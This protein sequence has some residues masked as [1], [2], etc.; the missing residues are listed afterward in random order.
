MA[1]EQHTPRIIAR[2]RTQSPGGTLVTK[3]DGIYVRYPIKINIGGT[4]TT[5]KVYQRLGSVTDSPRDIERAR[6]DHMAGVASSKVKPTKTVLLTDFVEKTY[7]PEV[8]QEWRAST[9]HSYTALWKLHIKP[10]A[11][12]E[13]DRPMLLRDV[14]THD[15]QRWLDKIAKDAPC[16]DHEQDHARLSRNSLKRI[17]S[18]ISAIFK[19]AAQLGYY[20]DDKNPT[21]EARVNRRAPG[22]VETYAY[23]L[24]EIQAILQ[25]LPEPAATIFCTASFTGLRSGELEGLRWEDLRDNALYIERAVYDGKIGEAKTKYSVAPVPLLRQ[26]AQRLSIHKLR[27]G[28]PA[29]GPIFR[30]AAGTPLDLRNVL[31][32]QVLPALERC[33]VCSMGKKHKNH[34]VKPAYDGEH[35]Y[36]AP[37]LKWAGWHACRRG[38]ASNLAR[39]GVQPKVLQALLRHSDLATTMAYYVKVVDEQ[40]REAMRT[41]EDAI[42]GTLGH[43][44]SGSGLPSDPKKAPE[45]AKEAVN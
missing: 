37:A 29:T 38:L 16:R 13:T 17:K 20:A 44:I 32:R 9:A 4:I 25:V 33:T 21:R 22:P 27:D 41:M 14:R 34:V 10:H 43:Q 7:L 26:L 31:K 24:E 1:T 12:S 15:V 19:R 36:S 6:A 45:G 39:L 5:K 8:E 2:P 11:T 30:T 3:A 42:T 23:S 35:Q 28:D 40:G 18:V